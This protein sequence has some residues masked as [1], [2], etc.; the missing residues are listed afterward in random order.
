MA[1]KM[2]YR[3]GPLVLRWV[4]KSATVDVEQ[5]D[6]LR[7]ITAGIVTPCSATGDAS[8]ICGIAMSA[9]PTSD[10]SGQSI[11]MAEI[12]H[13]TVFEMTVASATYTVGYYFNVTGNQTLG[14]IG[15]LTS[16]ASSG[17]NAVAVCAQEL[18]TA[19]TELLV[20][21]LPGKLNAQILAL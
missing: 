6:I 20:S 8:S 1:N 16:F 9:S 21:F 19:G 5:G 11:R 7:W 2:R 13:G 14:T 17:T 12:G 15:E 10:S 3:W 18:A 4:D